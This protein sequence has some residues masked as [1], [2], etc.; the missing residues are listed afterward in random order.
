MKYTLSYERV[1]GRPAISREK[2]YARNYV[3][4]KHRLR[5][6]HPLAIQ[7]IEDAVKDYRKEQGI[8]GERR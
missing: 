5:I 4:L 6:S 8:E 7:A 3:E 2:I 1:F